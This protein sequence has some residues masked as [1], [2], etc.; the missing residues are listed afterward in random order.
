MDLIFFD[1]ASHTTRKPTWLKARPFKDLW[2]TA[3]K[4]A[5]LKLAALRELNPCQPSHELER[6]D[7]FPSEPQMRQ[8]W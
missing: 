6:V 1:K 3:S 5:A 7:P 8:P 2:L 4:E